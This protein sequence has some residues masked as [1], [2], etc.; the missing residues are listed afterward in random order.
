MKERRNNDEEDRCSTGKL[1]I[2]KSLNEEQ[3]ERK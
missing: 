2:G 3:G 1:N